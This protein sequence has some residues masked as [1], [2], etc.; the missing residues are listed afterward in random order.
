MLESIEDYYTY[1]VLI[2]RIS[3]ELFWNADY[4]FLAKVLADKVAYDRYMTYMAQK[5]V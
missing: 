1:L 2:M 5:E 3:E 4:A